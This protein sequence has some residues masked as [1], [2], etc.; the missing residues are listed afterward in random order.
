ML[1]EAGIV[2]VGVPGDAG[3]S[4]AGA[5]PLED[6]GV[7]ERAGH[8]RRNAGV[9][10]IEEQKLL[11]LWQVIDKQL[12][13][14]CFRHADAGGSDHDELFDQMRTEDCQFYSG[15]GTEREADD[16]NW[17]ELKL[18]DQIDVVPGVIVDVANFFEA[19]GIG[20]AGM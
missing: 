8:G 7:V 10:L 4:F 19:L 12:T 3:G 9:V 11:E 16:G 15:P 13:H 18:I 5:E 2:K 1:G 6:A 17:A 20:K 14:R